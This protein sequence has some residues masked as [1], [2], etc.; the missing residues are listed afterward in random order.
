MNEELEKAYEADKE[1]KQVR[2]DELQAARD[3]VGVLLD[4][5]E[6]KNAL[7]ED[8]EQEAR[9]LVER[10]KKKE[11]EID[12]LIRVAESEKKKNRLATFWMCFAL[13]ELL[14]IGVVTVLLIIHSGSLTDR[15]ERVPEANVGSTQDPGTTTD[16]VVTEEVLTRKYTED[17]T[18]KINT[19]NSADIAP[20]TASVGTFDGLE[21]LV[22]SNKD[23][24]VA[25]KNEY[26]I[27]ESDYKKA[28]MIDNGTQRYTISTVYDLTGDPK[29]LI[30]KM[31]MLDDRQ[32]LFFAEYNSIDNIPSV[33]RFVDCSDFRSYICD[34]F[35][36][37]IRALTVVEET[38]ELSVYEDAPIVY[39]LTTD[40]GVYKYA[41]SEG[42]YNDI[43]YNQN[44]IPEIDTEFVM[45]VLEDGIAWKTNVK[46]NDGLYLGGLSGGLKLNG[47]R[48]E[49]ASAKFGAFVPA[50]QEDP[51]LGG[52]IRPVSQI[53]E[54]YLTVFGNAGERYFVSRNRDIPE[55]TYDWARLNT[56]DPNNWYYTDENGQKISYRGID[57]S[58]YQASINW[59][60]VADAGVEYAIIRMGFRGM[61][62]GT[63]EKDQYFDANMKGAIENGIKVGVY[64]FSQAVNEKE[65]IQ[66]AEFVLNAIKGYKVE[67]PVIFDTERVTTY[68][69]RANELN[70]ETRTALCRTFCGKI[71]EAGYKPMIYANTK[72]MIMG[73][74]LTK[75]KDIDKWFAVYSSSITYPYD[76]QMLQ[77]SDSGSIPG[78]PGKVD[79]DISFVDYSASDN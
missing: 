54:E 22:F 69:A 44:T 33:M 15:S 74:D 64:F 56:D 45:D 57:V 32:M 3:Y 65:A 50:N 1:R 11:G 18:E 26:Y 2:T 70:M 41:V 53:P 68:N 24:K 25:Y 19:L 36:E 73:I 75:L 51:E 12:D 6:G 71:A 46:L 13:I 43:A 60:K 27:D 20:F 58:K 78:V 66:E 16:P 30:P 23:I 77:Y 9:E 72:Y 49:I 34:D 52:Y 37:I 5:A 35:Q 7:L 47:E 10:L 29:N 39:S 40:K 31:T 55:C 61:N 28:V 62:E 79:L 48:I 42:D 63:L 59:K 17:L 67:Y 21:Y 14:A 76:F 38:E 4:E 8:K